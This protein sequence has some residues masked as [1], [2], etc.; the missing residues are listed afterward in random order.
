M[1]Q[2][3]LIYKIVLF[4]DS[5]ADKTSILNQYVHRRFIEDSKPTETELCIKNIVLDSDSI[6]IQ[7]WDTPKKNSGYQILVEGALGA[8]WCIIVQTLGHYRN[9]EAI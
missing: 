8:Y 2:P 6:T 4:G 5:K 1:N 3:N 7:I 9:L